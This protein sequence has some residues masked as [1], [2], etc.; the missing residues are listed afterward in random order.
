MP[1]VLPHIHRF[2]LV[3]KGGLKGLERG[4]R[5]SQGIE[6]CIHHITENKIIEKEEER[7]RKRKKEIERWREIERD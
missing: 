7:E 6:L 5:N 2:H 4:F 1:G 3:K